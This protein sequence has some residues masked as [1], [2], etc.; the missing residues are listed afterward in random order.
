LVTLLKNNT[1]KQGFKEEE[2]GPDDDDFE[3]GDSADFDIA[4]E[5]SRQ[6]RLPIRNS[7]TP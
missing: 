5:K 1:K 3:A 4:E 6:R 7:D 2:L